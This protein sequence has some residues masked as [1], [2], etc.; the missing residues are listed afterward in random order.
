MTGVL[1]LNAGSASLKFGLYDS[2]PEPVLRVSGQVD[3][4][5]AAARLIL[6]GAV[7]AAR[8]AIPGG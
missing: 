5:G 3:G 7:Q 6:P 4:I 8:F 2:A 1:T